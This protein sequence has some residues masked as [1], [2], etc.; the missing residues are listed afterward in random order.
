MAVFTC[1]ALTAQERYKMLCAAVVPRPVAW[2]TTVDETG[3]VNAAPYSFFNVFSQTPPLVIVGLDLREGGAQKDTLV[4]ARAAGAFTVNLAD[5]ALAPKMVET[6]AAFPPGISETEAVGL[7][8]APGVTIAVPRIA[9]APIALECA[10]YQI[11]EV[12]PAR[13][14]LMG[15]VK[16]I[17]ARDGLFDPDTK[18]L[19]VPHWDPVA[20][21]HATS[22]ARLGEPYDLP[23]P[24]WTTLAETTKADG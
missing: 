19:T 23:I 4:N 14:L 2:I 24:D 18:R 9:E 17:A 22:Y 3:A 20:R 5:H 15:E 8:T 7:T 1:D 12:G 6:A 11:V 10:V 21:L 16:A 13:S